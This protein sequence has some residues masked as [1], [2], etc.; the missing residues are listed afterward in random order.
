MINENLFPTHSHNMYECIND[1]IT[2]EAC[3]EAV[4]LSSS[5]LQ[6][7]VPFVSPQV[8]PNWVSALPACRLFYP[9]GYSLKRAQVQVNKLC[10]KTTVPSKMHNWFV[11]IW[12]RKLLVVFLIP[13]D[14]HA[15]PWQSIPSRINSPVPIHTSGWT[16][17]LWEWRV[18]S[19]ILVTQWLRSGHKAE[20]LEPEFCALTISLLRPPNRYNRT[21]HKAKGN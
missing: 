7:T 1:M 21:T 14:V 8:F 11:K 20:L 15:S 12:A 9:R 16:E 2:L 18:F 3:C 6:S 19:K 4:P 10:T 5:F 17:A 13:F